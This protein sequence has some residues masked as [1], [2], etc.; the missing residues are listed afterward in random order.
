MKIQLS[1]HF[2]YRRLL[3]FVFPSIVMMVFTS[4]YG[5]VDGLFVSNFV[6]KDAF[7]AINLIMPF[8]MIFGGVGFMFGTGGSALVAMTLG[9]KKKE[10]ANEYFTMIVAGTAI[11]GAIISLIACFIMR[12]VAIWLGAEGEIITDCVIYGRIMMIF[13]IAF[14]L[15]NAFQGFFI[16]AEK[17]HLGLVTTVAAGLTNMVLDA[18][19]VGV[20]KWGVA[21]AA[22]ATGLC[23]VVGGIIPLIYFILPNN[24]LLKMVRTKLEIKSIARACWNGASEFVSNT[25][26]S[27]VGIVYNFQLLKYAGSDGVAANGVLMYVQFIFIA[28]FIGY[29]MG[30]AP[31]ISYH[32]GAD[33]TDELRNM[34]KKSNIIM[35]IAGVIMAVLAFTLAGTLSKIFVGYDP[36]LFAMTKHVFRIFSLAF[37]FS[38][39]TIFASSFFTALNNGGVSAAIS[40]LR[41]FIFKMAAVLIMPL[42]WELD[43]I[44]WSVTIA[45]VFALIISV[46]FLVVY[47]KN[48]NYI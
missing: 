6:G 4:I 28:M 9:E 30:G 13:N 36:E 7:A 42:I 22:I 18:L 26:S 15:Q 12:P 39:F 27:I 10:R 35:G 29:A 20:L 23:Q 38:G 48:Y 16:T 21:G 17:P 45:E 47:R 32:Y 1:D 11:V 8:L 33:N 31:I 25:A 14:M 43:G 44:W 19:L 24:S 3:R 5:V 34:F 40:F 41:T 37:I 2:T 46:I